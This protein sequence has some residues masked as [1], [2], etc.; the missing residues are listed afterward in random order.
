M[1]PQK[2]AILSDDG[3]NPQAY[4]ACPKGTYPNQ[5]EGQNYCYPC[6]SCCICFNHEENNVEYC[7]S[8]GKR[9]VPDIAYDKKTF[10]LHYFTIDNDTTY[11][12]PDLTTVLGAVPFTIR[13]GIYPV[14]RANVQSAEV[15]FYLKEPIPVNPKMLLQGKDFK[16]GRVKGKDG[17]SAGNSCFYS[18]AT[19]RSTTKSFTLKPVIEKGYCTKIAVRYKGSGAPRQANF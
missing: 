12:D 6:L 14:N 18:P 3:T 9:I 1:H 13:R 7:D 2:T 10:E 16:T 19:D 4:I 11:D 17:K 8:S 15:I 5:C